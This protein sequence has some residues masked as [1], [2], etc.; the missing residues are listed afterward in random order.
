LARGKTKVE[1][2]LAVAERT[3][4]EAADTDADN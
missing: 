2:P 4:M 1:I 3:A